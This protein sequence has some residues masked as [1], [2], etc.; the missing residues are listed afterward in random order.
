MKGGI[1]HCQGNLFICKDG[2]VSQSKKACFGYAAVGS[3]SKA[4]SSDSSSEREARS[5]SKRKRR[6]S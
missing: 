4:D 1:S 2:T 5:S 6:G 3:G